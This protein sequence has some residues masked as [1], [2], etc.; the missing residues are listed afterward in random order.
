VGVLLPRESLA[1]ATAVMSHAGVEYET[2]ISLALDAA[3]NAGESKR[4]LMEGKQRSDNFEVLGVPRRKSRVID[5]APDCVEL[6]AVPYG[7]LHSRRSSARGTS[8]TSVKNSSDC[9]SRSSRK[10]R[11]TSL[12]P[13]NN[14]EKQ[15]QQQQQQKTSV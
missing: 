9:C 13:L 2:S 6:H 8:S 12:T 10:G 7:V 14:K 15:Q 11:W 5:P 4:Y 3:A 1:S